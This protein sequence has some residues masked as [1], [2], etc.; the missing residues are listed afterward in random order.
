MAKLNGTIK[1]MHCASCVKLIQMNFEDVK[2]IRNLNIDLKSG[3]ARVEFDEKLAG[4]KEISE[5]VKKSGY[6]ID[7]S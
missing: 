2:G 7:F 1:G 4:K 6:S 5:A 3:K